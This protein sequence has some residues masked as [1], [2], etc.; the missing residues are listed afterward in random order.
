MSTGNLS[1]DAFLAA[2]RGVQTCPSRMR[3]PGPWERTEWLDSWVR[4]RTRWG[5][6]RRLRGWWA[7]R[8]GKIAAGGTSWPLG[9]PM[10]RT[11]SFCGCCHP[12]DATELVRAGWWVEPTSKPHKLYLHPPKRAAMLPLSGSS[13]VVP[14]VKL[15]AAH[16]S[17][18]D[19]QTFN[20]AWRARVAQAELR[21]FHS[22]LTS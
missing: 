3:E 19:R 12:Y 17:E 13:G 14:P 9:W 5:W 7:R 16:L 18:A 2:R 1:A 4:G 10:P 20:E 22:E 21:Q 6:R 15:Y 11:C 8:T